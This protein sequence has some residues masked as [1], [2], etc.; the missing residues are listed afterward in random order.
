MTHGLGPKK[1]T[2][3]SG[4][5]QKGDA[6]TNTNTN[7]YMWYIHTYVMYMP[8]KLAAELDSDLYLR[9]RLRL[10]LQSDILPAFLVGNRR[11]ELILYCQTKNMIFFLIHS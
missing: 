4:R 1:E 9:L 7:I 3:F 8:K 11:R 10:R 5:A 2:C 6:N